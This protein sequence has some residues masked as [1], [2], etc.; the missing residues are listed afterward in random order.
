MA[1]RGA[2]TGTRA[3][4]VKRLSVSGLKLI[5]A[6]TL[7]QSKIWWN[8][9][10]CKITLTEIPDVVKSDLASSV[11][12]TGCEVVSGCRRV[13]NPPSNRLNVDI[14]ED[15]TAGIFMSGFEDIHGH[16]KLRRLVWS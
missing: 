2:Y 6:S 12:G 15:V 16:E 14:S 5:S 8:V 4:A 13:L 9:I 3:E 1:C 11:A 10:D 7:G